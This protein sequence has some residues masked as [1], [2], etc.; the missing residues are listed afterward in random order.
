MSSPATEIAGPAVPLKPIPR[1]LC[2]QPSFAPPLEY[3]ERYELRYVSAN[4]GIRW[5]NRW[6][7]VSTTCIGEYLGLE[8]I[9]DGVWNVHFGALKHGRLLVRKMQIEDGDCY[10]CPR[11]KVS[12]MSS[13]AHSG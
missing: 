11:T 1:V 9:D 5:N 8:E 2:V 4:G 3:P 6:V 13:T 10:P 12:P 7:N